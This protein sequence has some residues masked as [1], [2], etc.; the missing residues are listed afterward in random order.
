M[1]AS[2]LEVRPRRAL[3]SVAT[4]RRWVRC[5][6]RAQTLLHI[7]TGCAVSLSAVQAPVIV[8]KLDAFEDLTP[9]LG[10]GAEDLITRKT[11]CFLAAVQIQDHRQVKPS[12]DG[13]DIGDITDPDLVGSTWF[14]LI[15]Q[16]GCRSFARLGAARV[17]GCPRLVQMA[18]FPPTGNR[19]AKPSGPH[20]S[21]SPDI[22]PTVL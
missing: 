16:V 15:N 6:L 19:S 21:P 2:A 20:N 8:V 5:R 13:G 12:L 3:S 11:L 7:G 4:W 18:L 22:E 17:C 10:P 14:E 9:D 1:A